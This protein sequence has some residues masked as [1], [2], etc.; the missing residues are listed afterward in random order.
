V[1]LVSDIVSGDSVSRET[2]PDLTARP[3]GPRLP[4]GEPRACRSC[5]R[6][7]AP[8]ERRHVCVACVQRKRRGAETGLACEAC[9]HADRRVLRLLKVTERQI[10]ACGNG[11]AL[12]GRRSLS[13]AELQAE[14]AAPAA[15]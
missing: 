3:Y 10:T 13:L 14:V 9:G 6:A 11:A 12:A 8:E 1:A 15:A 2:E 5:T 7:I 4:I